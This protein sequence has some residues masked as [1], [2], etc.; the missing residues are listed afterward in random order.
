M[1]RPPA[2]NEAANHNH[3]TNIAF[4]GPDDKT[5][6]MMEAMSGDVLCA[7]VPVAGKKVFGLS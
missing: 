6:Y 3:R 7:Q 2:I 1:V 4:G 5:I